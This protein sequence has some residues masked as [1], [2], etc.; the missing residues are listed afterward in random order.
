MNTDVL[1]PDML[2]LDAWNYRKFFLP[3]DTPMH[4]VVDEVEKYI[5]SRDLSR[6]PFFGY[7]RRDRGALELWLA[8]ELVMT[9]AFSQIV[10]AAASRVQNVHV[11]SILVEVAAGEHGH[12]RSG[13][14]KRAHPWLLHGLRDSVGLP[15][16][17]V[18][19]A[20]PTIEFI[21]RLEESSRAHPLAA[22]AWIGVGNERLILPEY[23]AVKECFAV[24]W[25]DAD[26]EP[27]LQANLTEDVVHS[28]LCYTAAS[29]L[30]A[31]EDDARYYYD[32]AVASIE[33]RW[34]YFDALLEACR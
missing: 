17:D 21:R 26:Y 34:S 18:K 19:P 30:I 22:L 8:Q 10:L 16:E 6:H 1:P 25:K 14:A 28:R 7:A 12:V 23:K 32:Q 9:N 5:V 24:T 27:F 11:R 2:M 15:M 20:A 13:V 29:T 4:P 3:T 31:N 33:A